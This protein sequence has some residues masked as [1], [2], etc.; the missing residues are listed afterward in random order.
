MT[1]LVLAATKGPH[2]DWAGLSPVVA[3]LVGALVVLMSGL[4]RSRLIREHGVPALSLVTL[5]TTL[6]MCIWQ[7][8][9]R[10]DLVAGALRLDELSLL[11]TMIFV[12]AAS[13]AVLLSW[14]AAAPRESAHGEF[15]ALLLTSVA[16][17]VV[18]VA[19]QNLVTLFLGFELLSIPLYV[20]CAT[21]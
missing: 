13:A 9:R 6:G 17:M 5:A 16:G 1:G 4:L 18:L 14:R 21:E 20:L 12:V 15:H 3:L 2:I 8:G 19:A 10:E 7:W 11:L